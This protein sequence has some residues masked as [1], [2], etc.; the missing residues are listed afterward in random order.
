MY[1]FYNR[2][3]SKELCQPTRLLLNIVPEA[4]VSII[5]EENEIKAIKGKIKLFLF[6][7]NI[8]VYT[9]DIS[10]FSKAAA[11]MGNIQSQLYFYIQL[12]LEQHGL[13]CLGPLMC[14][15]LNK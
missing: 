3:R 4:L 2:F 13:D 9:E 15:S 8:M 6:Q 12:A 5:K 11:H 14:G 7:N 1:C 10:E